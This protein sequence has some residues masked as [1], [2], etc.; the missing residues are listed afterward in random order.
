MVL[1]AAL[2]VLGV[3]GALLAASFFAERERWAT[4]LEAGRADQLRGIGEQQLVALRTDWDT[5]ARFAQRPE[6]TVALSSAA[7]AGTATVDRWISRLSMWTYRGVVRA[8]DA[9][10]SSLD[11]VASAALVV[12]APRFAAMGALVARGEV[13]AEGII[14]AAP[15]DSAGAV[16]CGAPAAW[17]PGVVTAPGAIGPPGSTERPAAADDSTYSLF[18]GVPVDTLAARASL[19]LPGGAVVS[20]FQAGVAYAAGDL[21]LTGGDGSGLLVV[22]GTL[23]VSGSV[24][25]RGVIV[26]AGGIVVSGGR[27][28][29]SG[30]LLAGGGT[31]AVAVNSFAELDLVYDPC[32]IEAA[33]WHAGR[34]IFASEPA[35]PI[36]P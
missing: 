19:R 5:A 28:V 22:D 25:F 26:A 2:V 30:L 8:R 12:D 16:A 35:P 24:T 34:V 14:A 36:A 4:R 17:A 20:A 1:L 29:A 7:I 31:P 13:R 9:R 33:E 3:V 15:A 23:L 21:E 6:S 27:F 10:D 32:A 11:A 18:G